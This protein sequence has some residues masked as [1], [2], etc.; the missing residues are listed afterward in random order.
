MSFPRIL[1]P[2]V[3]G[4]A[5]VVGVAGAVGLAGAQETPSTTA[6][7]TPSSPAPDQAPDG[8]HCHHGDTTN[9]DNRQ[10]SNRRTVIQT[11]RV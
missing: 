3:V 8:R 10:L 5:L 2:L 6:P 4:A 9:P 7:S 11:I 1:V